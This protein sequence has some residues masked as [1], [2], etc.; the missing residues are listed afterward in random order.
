MSDMKLQLIISAVNN[1]MVQVLNQSDQQLRKFTTNG[2][3]HFTR[4]Q[5]HASKVWGAIGGMSNAAR[6]IGVGAGIGI[7]KSVIDDNLALEKTLMK[8][9]FNAQMTTKELAEMRKTAMDLSKPG[10]VTPLEVAMVELRLATAG[11]KIESIRE[12]TPAIT[13]AAPV[14]EAPANEIAD[15]VFDQAS[16]LGIKNERIPQMLDMLYYHATSGRFETMD[17]ARNAPQLMN[18]GAMVGMTGENGLNFMGALTQRMMRNATVSI[19]S[20]VATL[21]Q[22]GLGHITQRHYVKKLKKFGIDVPSYFNEKGEFKGEGGVEGIVA[23]TRKMIAKGMENPFKLSKAGFRDQYTRTFWLEMMRAV[24]ADDSDKHPNLLKMMERGKEAMES[25]QIAKN[26]EVWKESNYGKIKS[27][28]IEIAKAKV[29]DGAQTATGWV[30]DAA[31]HF[32]ENP[33]ATAGGAAAAIIG[34]RM[35]MNRLGGRGGAVA[36]AAA[37]MAGDMKVFVTNWPGEMKASQRMSKLPGRPA[38]VAEAAAAGGAATAARTMAMTAARLLPLLAL[39]GDSANKPEYN[40]DWAEQSD[41]A[42]KAKGYR[43]EKGWLFDSYVKDTP[44]EA[45]PS[46]AQVEMA[47]SIRDAMRS[48]DAAANRP[49]EIH[50]D[51]V[52]IAEVVNKVNGREARRQ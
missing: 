43:R 12:L 33:L 29:S 21:V 32:S 46:A 1:K 20:E 3:K 37:G 17:M 27:A 13:R 19:P 7:A 41:A 11:L 15:L 6:L 25:G 40:P 48:M 30:G 31:Q 28:Q 4:L 24:K 22:H 14:F 47:T 2:E 5:R 35:L 10:L 18:A 42:M 51:G 38:P 36:Q 9:R 34:G 50:L 16:K 8:L 45:P 52:K 44:Q 26:L 23:L 49:I 39:T